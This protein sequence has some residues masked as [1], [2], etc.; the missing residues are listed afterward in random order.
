MKDL[1]DA[2]LKGIWAYL[3]TIPP[4]KNQVPLPV[5]PNAVKETAR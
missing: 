3:R 2:D 4:V 5:L 1:T